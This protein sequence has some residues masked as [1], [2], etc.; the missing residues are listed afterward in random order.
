MLRVSL[1]ETGRRRVARLMIARGTLVAGTVLVGG[2]D[3]AELDADACNDQHEVT[4]NDGS[5]HWMVGVSNGEKHVGAYCANSEISSCDRRDK[6]LVESSHDRG[7]CDC[8]KISSRRR[9]TCKG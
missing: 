5:P 6:I 9:S 2:M 8:Q 1:G 4:L 7:W 3:V